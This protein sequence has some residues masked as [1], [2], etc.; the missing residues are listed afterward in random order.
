MVNALAAAGWRAVLAPVRHSVADLV[1]PRVDVHPL[2]KNHGSGVAGMP[3]TAIRFL[4]L[5]A[6]VRPDVMHANSELPELLVALAARPG[7]GVVATEHVLDPWH[8]RPVIGRLVRGRLNECGALWTAPQASMHGTLP[9]DSLRVIPNALIDVARDDAWSPSS[10]T[11]ALRVV[12]VGRLIELKRQSW[13]VNAATA[14]NGRVQVTLIGDGSYRSVLERA[15]AAKAAPVSFM[16]RLHDPWQEARRHDVFVSTSASETDG[17]SV[18]EA[19]LHRMPVLASAIPAHVGLGLRPENLFS[20]ESELVDRLR[21]IVAEPSLLADAI[22]R[23][24]RKRLLAE[25]A[26][27][28]VASRFAAV[29]D[30]ALGRRRAGRNARAVDSAA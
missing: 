14:L 20:S 11:G 17:L 22:P 7:I 18:A 27:E 16:G 15:V 4:R 8:H 6:R 28:V 3:L 19:I 1:E 2:G 25:R 24:A 12:C 23:D 29:Y 30:E 10:R 13:L 5:V 26:P 9:D 21:R